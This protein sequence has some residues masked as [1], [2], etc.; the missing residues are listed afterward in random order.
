M[1]NRAYFIELY[2]D[3][4]DHVMMT[5]IKVSIKYFIILF[6]EINNKSIRSITR[7]KRKTNLQ[8]GLSIIFARTPGLS[9][10]KT[11]HPWVTA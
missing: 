4:E 1:I 5:F 10:V 7:M 11:C 9:P 6:V 3:D 8:E 2:D